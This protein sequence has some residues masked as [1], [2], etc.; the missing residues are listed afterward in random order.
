MINAEEN[1]AAEAPNNDENVAKTTGKPEESER[2]NVIDSKK[3]KSKEEDAI[4]SVFTSEALGSLLE[5]SGPVCKCVLIKASDGIATEIDIDMTPKENNAATIL[6]GSPTFIGQFIDLNVVVMK[7]RNPTPETVV[8]PHTLPHPFHKE[9]TKGNILLLRM[10]DASNPRDFT[11][12]EYL[13]YVKKILANPP[14]DVPE[15][16][17]AMVDDEEEELG[18]TDEDEEEPILESDSEEE[19]DLSPVQQAI[20]EQV[21]VKYRENNNRDPTEEELANLMKQLSESGAFQ[22][23]VKRLSGL[24]EENEAG[25]KIGEENVSPNKKRSADVITDCDEPKSTTA[26]KAKIDTEETVVTSTTATTANSIAN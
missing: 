16:A 1:V 11:L 7:V 4:D 26:K 17:A 23:I 21:I 13:S 12:E 5:G 15:T 8:N 3:E 9:E 25:E 18:D 20:L 10:D 2:D 22:A 6:G 24:G 14:P 19:G